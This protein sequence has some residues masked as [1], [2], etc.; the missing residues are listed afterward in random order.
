MATAPPEAVMVTPL[1]EGAISRIVVEFKNVGLSGV[2]LDYNPVVQVWDI[3][4]VSNKVYNMS[5]PLLVLSDG[6]RSHHSVLSMKNDELVMTMTRLR[7][8]SLIQLTGFSF[9]ESARSRRIV[10][11]MLKVISETY[12]LIGNPRCFSKESACDFSTAL[13]LFGEKGDQRRNRSIGS[14]DEKEREL[15]S[16]LKDLANYKVQLEA[17]EAAYMQAE[18]KLDQSQKT[19]DELSALIKNSETERDRYETEC[20]GARIRLEE[21]ESEMKE[22]ADR[23]SETASIREQL[24]QVLDELKTARGELIC[25]ETELVAAKDSEREALKQAELI[26]LELNAERLKS[27]VLTKQVSELDE[28]FRVLNDAAVKAQKERLALLSE[29]DAEIEVAKKALVEA[30]EGLE[31]MKREMQIMQESENQLFSM[32]AFVD[33]LRL[34][35]KEANERLSFSEK[36]AVVAFTDLKLIRE[37]MEFKDRKNSSQEALIE[38]FKMETSELKHELKNANELASHLMADVEMLTGDLHK[39][40]AEIDEIRKKEAEAQVEIALLKSELHK[41]RSKIAAAEAAEARAE[42]VKSGLYLA[43]QELAVEAESAKKENQMLK[44]ETYKEIESDASQIDK[45]NT[46][47]E[48]TKDDD[49]DPIT[50]AEKSDEQIPEAVIEDSSLLTAHD[51][52]Q[53]MENLR[54]ELDAATAKVAEFRNRAEQAIC[55]AE[56]AE[57]AKTAIEDQLR[58]WRDERQKK[59]AALAALKEVSASREISSISTENK[60]QVTYY[61]PLYKVL[62]MKF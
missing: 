27:A 56:M 41:G 24:S 51:H 4:I 23:L 10:V 17:K 54:K 30:E 6:S 62:N 59:K 3:R 61:Q 49:N 60:P 31:E 18:L 47:P 25:K 20:R 2:I 34:Q 15:E 28:I 16:V 35:L 13:S 1:T 22:M 32:S 52:K 9:Y 11:R 26:E 43:V 21:S 42:S 45:P 12:G 58:K 44:Q 57:R 14:D 19:V 7:K 48:E 29:K 33:T 5:Y 39:A 50:S 53:E 40:M 55:R 37:E 36:S 8:G 38:A 46:E